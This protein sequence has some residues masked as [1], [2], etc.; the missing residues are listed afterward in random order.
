M[1]HVSGP[2]PIHPHSFTHVVPAS[3]IIDRIIAIAALTNRPSGYGWRHYLH[4][5]HDEVLQDLRDHAAQLSLLD[6]EISDGVFTT[7]LDMQVTCSFQH[8]ADM[9]HFK[10][11]FC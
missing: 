7:T 10:L 5:A 1:K 6:Y 9:M 8:E 2:V 11:A 3:E 4:D